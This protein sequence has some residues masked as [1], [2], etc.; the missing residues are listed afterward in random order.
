MAEKQQIFRQKSLDKVQSVEDLDS[1][2]KTTTPSLW[3]LLSA[4]IVLL[5]GVIVFS[6][7]GTIKASTEIGCSINQKGTVYI[8]EEAYKKLTDESYVLVS[9]NKCKITNITGPFLA[10]KEKDSYLLSSNKISLD[11]W[12]YVVEFDCLLNSGE[13][14]GKLVFEEVKPISF[15]IN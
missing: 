12:F 11:Q 9:D 2:I 14:Y 4:I 10:D 5:V 6:C 8:T 13:Y 1:Y 3:L 15:I 7:V